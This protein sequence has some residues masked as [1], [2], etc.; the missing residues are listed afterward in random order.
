M[1]EIFDSRRCFLGEGPLWHPQRKQLFWFDIINRE[2]LTQSEGKTL[3]WHFREMASAAGWVDKNH[4]LIAFEDSLRCLN[5][6]TGYEERIVD[7]EANNSATRSND[8]RADPMGGF[9]IGTMGKQAQNQAGAI[10]RYYRGELRK[11]HSNLSI[12]NSICFSP[13]GRLLYFA[14]TAQQRIW[15]Q[16]LDEM[17]WPAGDAELFIDLSAKGLFPDGSCI[18]DRGNLWNAQWGS[19]SVAC[20][21]P[22][23]NFLSR[24]YVGGA[25]STCPAFGGD[26]FSEI[27]I[28]T[29]Q[30]GLDSP[31]SAD[32]PVYRI[33]LEGVTGQAEPRVEL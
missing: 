5:L 14:D 1:F 17:G 15:W 26:K 30:E 22:Q 8:G 27:F 33:T 16:P 32:G 9:W 10:Y 31:T 18:D 28:T 13:D 2:L 19:G 24:L 20:Y 3:N 6:N 25:H 12:P 7:L 29:A 21:S 23:G 11:I 4:L